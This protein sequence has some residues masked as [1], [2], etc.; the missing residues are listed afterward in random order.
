[1]FFEMGR[2]VPVGRHFALTPY[3]LRWLQSPGLSDAN[4]MEHAR[5]AQLL[6]RHNARFGD[7]YRL[8]ASEAVDCYEGRTYFAC[9]AM[10]GAA[11]ES[12]L[13]ALAIAKLGEEEALMCMF[14]HS[15]AATI[16]RRP[17]LPEP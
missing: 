1:V 4:P 5:F 11:A 12:I 10:C 14:T 6:S 2:A 15:S 13:L 3:G 7:A 16:S 9:C 17:W 8:R